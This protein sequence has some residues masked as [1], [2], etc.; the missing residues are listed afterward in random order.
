MVDAQHEWL[1]HQVTATH[2][3][4]QHS[5]HPVPPCTHTH[6]V[7]CHSTDTNATNTWCC[8]SLLVTLCSCC[9]C[10]SCCMA[11]RAQVCLAECCQQPC[12]QLA[13]TVW[14]PRYCCY[15]CCCCCSSRLLL[16]LLQDSD[17]QACL[18]QSCQQAC[19]QLALLNTITSL[20]HVP[21]AAAA[22]AAPPWAI[23]VPR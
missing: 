20:V 3:S 12:V 9:C 10:Y 2:I 7:Q 6:S 13:P 23:Q 19:V 16:L 1:A 21:A 4:S 18:A 14:H 17:A 11:V 15:C 8:S 5:T 22:A